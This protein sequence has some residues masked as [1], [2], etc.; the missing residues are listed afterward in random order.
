[1]GMN[2]VLYYLELQKWMTW[3]QGRVLLAHHIGNFM[4]I[5]FI[6][7]AGENGVPKDLNEAIS[8]L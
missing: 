4:A 1:M 2:A 8:H 7:K 6:F 3:F 5:Y